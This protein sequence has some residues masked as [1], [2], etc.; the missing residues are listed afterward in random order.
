M[1]H[2][3]PVPTPAHFA[4]LVGDP[5]RAYLQT[6]PSPTT[7]QWRNHDYWSKVKLDLYDAYANAP[8]TL[9]HCC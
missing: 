6:T 3:N 1:M 4:R 2:V 5:G 9:A 8:P 7:A